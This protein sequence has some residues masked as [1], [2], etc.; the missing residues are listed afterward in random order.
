MS[1]YCNAYGAYCG[2]SIAFLL[3]V[4]SGLYPDMVSL[5][6]WFEPERKKAGDITFPFKTFLMLMNFVR[7]LRV[8]YQ[9]NCAH[10]C[11]VNSPLRID[12]LTLPSTHRQRLPIHQPALQKHRLP[13][14]IRLS[15][16]RTFRHQRRRARNSWLRRIQTIPR[17]RSEKRI[18]ETLAYAVCG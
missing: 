3:R 4:L 12:Q 5:L 10:A 14:K 7:V 18:Y 1:H 16:P 15:R 9:S 2:Y 13:Q 8:C 11:R 17:I 6:Y